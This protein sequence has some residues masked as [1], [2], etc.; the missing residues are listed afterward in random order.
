MTRRK[1]STADLRKVLGVKRPGLLGRIAGGSK[2]KPGT[3]AAG[4]TPARGLLEV[5]RRAIDP[6]PIPISLS[7][8]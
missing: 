4:G 8:A 1:S 5:N 7:S 2:P 3:P 6:R